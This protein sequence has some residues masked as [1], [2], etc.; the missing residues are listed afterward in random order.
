[1][2]TA[3]SEKPKIFVNAAVNWLGFLVQIGITFF[4]TPILF[5]ALGK[6]RYGIFSVVESILTYLM[7]FDFGVGASVV[8]YV[9]KFEATRD[10]QSLNRVFSTSLCIFSVA[11]FFV[12]A[13][14]AAV[15]G[16]ALPLI[17]VSVFQIRPEL[18]E[19]SRWLLVLLGLNLGLGFPLG[20]FAC[21]LDGLRRFPAKMAIRTSVLVLR[22]ILLVIIL[23]QG[24]GLI[25]VGA[26]ITACS[27]LEYIGLA[28]AARAYLP[29]LRFSLA[30][31]DR[32]TFRT[33]GGYSIH[34]FL[35][36]VAGRICFQTDAL[37][38]FPALGPA[39]VAVFAIAAK[40]VEYSKDS[41]RVITSVLTPSVSVLDARGNIDAIR[42]LLIKSTRYV[43]WLILPVQIGL[44]A[45]GKPFIGLWMENPELA[46]LCFPI[47][48]ILAAPMALTISQS[49]SMRILYGTSRLRWFARFSLVEAVAN[50]VLSVILVQYCNLEGV[51][52]GTMIPNILLNVG[53]LVYICRGFQVPIKE[54]LRRSFMPPLIPATILAGFWL[55]VASVWNLE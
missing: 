51:A 26:V 32:E 53:L 9:S 34:A 42:R 13:L 21:L 45:L 38:I 6:D 30:L 47:L 3:D 37:V 14:A 10:Q 16:W 55:W 36:M 22:G 8:R 29:G 33:I 18:M 5:G 43:L 44:L 41:L 48:V 49:V 17:K 7:L 31:I 46:E 25:H 23:G 20:V 39:A 52:L 50:L 12:F 24:G 35:I 11:G 19:Q 15:A 1:M 40:L 2:D 28:F 4:L 27:L 54:Y